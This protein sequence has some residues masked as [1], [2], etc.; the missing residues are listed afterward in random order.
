[1]K[2]QIFTTYF[3]FIF[4]IGLLAV[5]CNKEDTI[6]PEVATT[7]LEEAIV[8]KAKIDRIKNADNKVIINKNQLPKK[9]KDILKKKYPSSSVNRTY[10]VT[11]QGFEVMLFQEQQN[12]TNRTLS[13]VYFNNSGV[14]LLS[15]ESEL[16]ANG[17][18]E[19][20]ALCFEYVYPITFLLPGGDTLIVAKD[21]DWQKLDQ[22][23]D[24]HQETKAF[25]EIKF[26][27][28]IVFWD[29]TQGSITNREVE[30][31]LIEECTKAIAEVIQILPT[32]ENQ[33]FP[34]YE[35]LTQSCFN[36][37][38]VYP[39]TF[40][41]PEGGQIV[42]ENASDWN[43]LDQWYEKNIEIE[44]F[45][46]LVYPVSLTNEG[47][48]VV[49]ETEAAAEEFAKSEATKCILLLFVSERI[50]CYTYT[51]PV[52]IVPPNGGEKVTVNSEEELIEKA[53]NWIDDLDTTETN[54]GE[55]YIIFPTLEYPVEMKFQDGKVEKATSAAEEQELFFSRCNAGEI[56]DI[57]ETD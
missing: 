1:M 45:P 2:K 39:I 16:E 56:D 13:P 17:A 48:T 28:N 15:D 29:G 7:E 18:V 21:E 32:P 5:S 49:L 41:L 35:K 37:D 10:S 42:L 31:T 55:S 3:S 26:P 47:K 8:D 25:P 27:V 22:W 46:A 20:E 57:V 11:D 52:T 12:L 43:L 38:Y 9:S 33:V 30:E 34:P 50:N 53:S 44:I 4:F 14:Q 6:S 51:Y 36:Y 23:Y 24:N 19:L 40:D 54:E